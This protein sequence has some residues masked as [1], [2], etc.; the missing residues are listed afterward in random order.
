VGKVD[1]V[2]LKATIL[3]ALERERDVL[4]AAQRA[5]TAGVVHEDSRA[6]GD[7][8]MRS[9]EAS[10]LARGQA[11]RVEA[12]EGDIERVR[13]MSLADF[14]GGAPIA[15]SAVVFLDKDGGRMRAFIAPAGGGMSVPCEGDVV[16]VVTHRSPLGRALIG[17]R[18]GDVVE[19]ERG[20]DSVDCE[21]LSVE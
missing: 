14:H 17:A 1:K 10:Y 19:V 5:T 3:A 9:T 6:E 18:A 12:L 2:A 16:Q 8:D 21:V 7:K 13:A 4:A 20:T 15:L 11:A